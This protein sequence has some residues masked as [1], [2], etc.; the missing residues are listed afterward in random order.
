MSIIQ[1]IHQLEQTVSSQFKE[2]FSKAGHP[3]TSCQF[4]V[5]RA[6][7]ENDGAS[8]TQIVSITGVDRSILA[9]VVKRLLE[10]KLL[11]RYKSKQDARAYVLSIT[12]E[13]SG[14]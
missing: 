5:L 8:Q 3:I 9:D 13:G 11:T 6:I 2:A 1:T 14:S 7:Q 4:M 12:E 10:A